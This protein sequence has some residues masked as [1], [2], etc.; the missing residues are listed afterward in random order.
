MRARARRV[1]RR[2]RACAPPTRAWPRAPA[3]SRA[4]FDIDR[5]HTGVDLCDAASPLRLE[6]RPL[7]EPAPAVLG[8]PADRHRVRRG[9]VGLRPVAVRRRGQPVAQPP[10]PRRPGDLIAA[11]DARS[12][13]LL[14]FPAVR[15]RLAEQT[16]FD[17]SRRL[18]EAPRAVRRPGHRRPR[19]R[20]DRPGAR[21]APGAARRRDRG[22]ARHRAV[23]RRATRGGRLDAAQFLEIIETLDA[24]ARLATSLADERRSLLRD[25][26]RRL[27]PLP[28]L[29]GTLARSFD[30]AGELLDTASP[31]LGPL[32]AGGPRRLRP[33]APAPG[34]ARRLGAR[35]R[36]PGA[37]RDAPQ[38][39]LRGPGPGRGAVQGQGHRPRRVGQRP[40]A[41]RRAAGRRRAGQRLARG[42]GGRRRG[43]GPHPRRAVVAGRRQRHAA[44]RD[45]RG[46]RPVRLLGGQ[47][48]PGRGAR[49]R[50]A[51][52]APTGPRSSCCR[53][54][55]PGSPGASSR[56]TSG[57]ATATRRS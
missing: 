18:A 21:P 40:D 35:R 10:R 31:R 2:G 8:D 20:R 47:G 37:D 7:D 16:S 43:G 17:P 53:R 26:G 12:I 55:I 48:A 46:A 14:E 38:R 41:V 28:A 11:M 5:S 57:S 9:A 19:A 50:P 13:A 29:R 32:R 56:S 49:R 22:G 27:H 1:R 51:R 54:A 3:S 44:A 6:A 42:P 34:L 25:L 36:A 24:A 45:A 39:P 30:P 52:A 23:D 15:A 4:A 33:A